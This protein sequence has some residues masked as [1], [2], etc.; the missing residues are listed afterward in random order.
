[1][2][3]DLELL[4][5]VSSSSRTNLSFMR[6]HFSAMPVMTAM[7]VFS[8]RFIIMISLAL[9]APIRL[10]LA[11]QKLSLSSRVFRSLTLPSRRVKSRKRWAMGTKVVYMS[12]IRAYGASLAALTAV[13]RSANVIARLMLRDRDLIAVVKSLV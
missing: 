12:G 6:P 10:Q 7:A 1:M 5:T 9:R 3:L 8:A 2:V 13:R 4:S 11:L